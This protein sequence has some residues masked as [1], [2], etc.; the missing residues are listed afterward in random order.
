[1]A[2][3]ICALH[4]GNGEEGFRTALRT[5]C[6]H[7]PEGVIDAEHDDHRT[8]A[9]GAHHRDD[10]GSCGLRHGH[11]IKS[12]PGDACTESNK[13]PNRRLANPGL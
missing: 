5:D 2:I 1:M 10:M 13:P 3:H 6:L 4:R 8:V 7:R 9:E 11:S 12:W